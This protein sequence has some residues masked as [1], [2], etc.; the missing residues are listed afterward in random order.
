MTE[1]LCDYGVHCMC[2]EPECECPCDQ[3]GGDEK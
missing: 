2:I 3:H 1:T